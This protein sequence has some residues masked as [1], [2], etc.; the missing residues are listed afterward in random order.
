MFVGIDIG[1]SSVKLV[2]GNGD[3]HETKVLPIGAAPLRECSRVHGGQAAIG[4]GQQILIDGEPWVGGI[5]P[6]LLES[7]EAVMDTSYPET[8]RYRALFYAALATIG[9]T[10]IDRLIT[11]LPVSHFQD[12][13]KREA[14]RQRMQG[15]HYISEDMAVEVEH[16][17]I[18]PQPTGAFSAFVVGAAAKRGAA[19]YT[20]RESLLVVDPG[21][22]SMDWVIHDGAFKLRSSGSTVKA[23]ELVVRRAAEDLTASEGVTVRS[24]RL[25]EAVLAGEESLR[26]GGREIHFWDALQTAASGVIAENLAAMGGSVRSVLENRGVD[27]V[28]VTGGGAALFRQALQKAF[29]ESLVTVVDDSITANAR[30]FFHYAVRL[31]SQS[32]AA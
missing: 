19:V 28:L 21:H 1:Y 12:E 30:G 32:R 10:K 17:D 6:R 5:E 3:N 16:V 27:I 25:Q 23:G 22:Y 29:P 14:L 11:G 7:F 24:V 18:V 20:G 9:A 13:S 15:R 8:T 4:S 2:Y 31:G 26:I